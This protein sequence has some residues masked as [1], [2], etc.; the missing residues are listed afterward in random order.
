[1]L[2]EAASVLGYDLYQS[3]GTGGQAHVRLGFNKLKN[4]HA[5]IKILPK[6]NRILPQEYK[7]EILIHS[8]VKHPNI[9]KLFENLD[10]DNH[11]YLIMEYA[12]SGELFNKI[13]PD[14]GI[15]EDVVHFYAKQLLN[16]IKYLHNQGIAHRDLKPE[17][18]LLDEQGNLKLSDFG[19]ATIFRRG[20]NTRILTTPCGTPPYVAPEIHLCRYDGGR[21]DIWSY[22]VIIYVMLAGNTPW[23]EPTMRDQEYSLYLAK[24]PNSLSYR[25][26]SQFS[27]EVLNLLVRVLNPDPELRYTLGDI[28]NNH[29][30]KLDN[31]LMQ[32]NGMCNNPRLLAE[33]LESKGKEGDIGAHNNN[34]EEEDFQMEDDCESDFVAYSQPIMNDT[35][36]FKL[37]DFEVRFSTDHAVCFSQPVRDI[38]ES[39]LGTN[40]G[41]IVVF[42]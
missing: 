26:F 22:G 29:W 32:Q 14:I 30:V 34:I 12:I 38:S 33:K 24:Y 10:T 37:P 42:I 25:P 18:M 39:P 40:L 4:K 23:A 1:M 13:E 35:N 27:I 3:I 8:S 16:S 36:R 15:T 17:N 6:L 9:I 28:S 21:V 11:L 5:A 2:G 31:P 20:N 41:A 7:K 19:L